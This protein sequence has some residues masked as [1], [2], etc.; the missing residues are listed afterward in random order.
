LAPFGQAMVAAAS[1]G[2]SLRQLLMS[3]I[4]FLNILR[5]FNYKTKSVITQQQIFRGRKILTLLSAFS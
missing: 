1:S 2:Q 4:R 5:F 3:F